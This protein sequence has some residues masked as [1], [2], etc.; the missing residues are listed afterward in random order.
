MHCIEVDQL[1]MFSSMLATTGS[2]IS[3]EL[4]LRGMI[5]L[6]ICSKLSGLV[7]SSP[8]SNCSGVR[9]ACGPASLFCL[10]GRNLQNQER[11]LPVPG[12]PAWS[13]RLIR[14]DMPPSYFALIPCLERWTILFLSGRRF[15]APM[16]LDGVHEFILFIVSA[17]L[18]HSVTNARSHLYSL[19]YL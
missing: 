2:S 14:H 8:G 15:L 4:R 17:Q 1:P 18:P 9:R 3:R 12:S 16:L 6:T 19:I 10:K 13:S 7:V 5:R 11:L